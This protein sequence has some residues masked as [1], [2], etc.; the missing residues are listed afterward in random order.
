MKYVK[1]SFV[2]LREFRDLVDANAQLRAWLLGP[3]G[4][5]VHGTTHEP[6]LTRFVETE[7]EFLRPLPSRPPELAVWRGSSRHSN[8]WIPMP[9]DGE[10]VLS[11][12]VGSKTSG[13]FL[14]GPFGTGSEHLASFMSQHADTLEQ[15]LGPNQLTSRGHYYG[16]SQDIAVQQESRWDELIDWMEAQRQR[17]ADVFRIIG[18]TSD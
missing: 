11:M 2:P 10:V 16:T 4:N 13:M 18:G 15:A 5:R 12:Y 7:H 8:V 17:Y 1:R 6:P 3:A 14:H 9:P